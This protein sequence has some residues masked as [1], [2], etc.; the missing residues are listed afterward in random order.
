M[1]RD[2][3]VRGHL[4]SWR[5][6]MRSRPRGR[7]GLLQVLVATS[8]KFFASLLHSHCCTAWYLG[9]AP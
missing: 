2:L 6:G 8:C 4:R 3:E 7:N 1:A 9:G 5:C